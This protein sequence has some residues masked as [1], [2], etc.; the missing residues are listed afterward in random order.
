MTW[1]VTYPPYQKS[2]AR[3]EGGPAV[4][5]TTVL[6]ISRPPCRS[7]TPAHVRGRRARI[8][9]VGNRNGIAASIAIAGLAVLWGWGV[10]AMLH[11][12]FFSFVLVRDSPMWR[13]ALI[14]QAAMCLCCGALAI[15]QT[16]SALK[17]GK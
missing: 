8:A 15:A 2:R 11:D 4:W 7:V 9:A 17:K 3:E 12:E 16:R 6:A 1:A 13:V 10:W 14:A 5:E